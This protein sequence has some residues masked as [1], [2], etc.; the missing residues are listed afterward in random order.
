MVII[1][2]IP[3]CVNDV[4]PVG[5]KEKKC[6]FSWRVSAA[7]VKLRLFLVLPANLVQLVIGH[8]SF[9][10]AWPFPVCVSG[11]FWSR[12]GSSA[13]R[14]S[15]VQG[16]ST[17]PLRAWRF[18]L[19][20]NG[21]MISSRSGIPRSRLGTRKNSSKWSRMSDDAPWSALPLATAQKTS[22][23]NVKFPRKVLSFLSTLM[24][25][26]YLCW[27][28]QKQTF[29]CLEERQ[30]CFVLEARDSDLALGN[31]FVDVTF[32]NATVAATASPHISDCSTCG[33]AKRR[34]RQTNRDRWP[35][36]D[37]ATSGAFNHS[38]VLRERGVN[39][40]ERLASRVTTRLQAVNNQ[41]R[42]YIRPRFQAAALI[43]RRFPCLGQRRSQ[44]RRK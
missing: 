28:R 12:R 39:I 27:F 20:G 4:R 30:T 10:L 41:P 33:V 36:Y 38:H 21:R 6:L 11:L 3:S 26:S 7:V 40:K 16:M 1:I 42:K 2:P 19:T 17:C 18:P 34:L 25:R 32:L 43:G 44:A 31:C 5:K 14:N 13:L 35:N 9:V 37:A 8:Q 15:H 24:L 23:G 22:W 29:A